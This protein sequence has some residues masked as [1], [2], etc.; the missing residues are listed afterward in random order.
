MLSNFNSFF[1]IIGVLNLAYA[2]SEG[3]RN[4]VDD[5]ILRLRDS[6]LPNVRERREEIVAR[7]IVAFSEPSQIEKHATFIIEKFET[8]CKEILEEEKSRQEF[9]NGFKSMFLATSIFSILLIIIAGYE[10]YFPWYT[11]PYLGV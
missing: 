7:I 6:I 9:T 8:D 5:E 10:Q 11:T 3:F 2:G 4:A 1:E